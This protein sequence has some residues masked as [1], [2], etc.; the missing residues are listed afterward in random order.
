V[1][2]LAGPAAYTLT[3]VAHP[4][5]GSLVTAGPSTGRSG[6]AG[7]FGGV[8][9]PGVSTS[10]PALITYLEANRGTATYLV[11]TSGSQSSASIIIASGQPVITIGGFNGGDP[12]PTLVQ[13]KAL[14]AAGKVRYLLAGNGVGGGGTPGGAQS[15]SSIAQW[16][17]S[18][19]TKV[20]VAGSNA[21]LYD[22]GNA[23]TS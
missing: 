4:V 19:G 17:A 15:G 3:T 11:A 23:L 14:V 7:G 22:L 1:A 9:G 12:A 6:G 5:S 16:A 8:G 13:F 10:D 18:A 20:T 21:T 2:L